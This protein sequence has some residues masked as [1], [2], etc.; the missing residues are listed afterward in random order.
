MTQP[1]RGQRNL[2]HKSGAKLM[3]FG[4]SDEA[5]LREIGAVEAYARLNFRSRPR[6][7]SKLMLH[8]LAGALADVDWPG[9]DPAHKAALAREGATRLSQAPR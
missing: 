3:E 9:L 7:V 5:A 4:V 2:G 8:A 1:L 6:T